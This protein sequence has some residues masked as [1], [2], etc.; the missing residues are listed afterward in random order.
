MRV[1]A[2]LARTLTQLRWYVSHAVPHA[3]HAHSLQL[4]AQPVSAPTCTTV[5]C[6]WVAAHLACTKAV[7]TAWHVWGHALH[8]KMQHIATLAHM[9]ICIM[10]TV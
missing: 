6:V 2:L 1:H 10:V 5:T 8:A 7:V 3:H 4:T 9:I